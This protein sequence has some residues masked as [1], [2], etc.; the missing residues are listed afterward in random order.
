MIATRITF[1]GFFNA[2]GMASVEREA[3]ERAITEE[4]QSWLPILEAWA[5]ALNGTDNLLMQV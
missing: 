2:G 1:D 3:A 4:R 5:A